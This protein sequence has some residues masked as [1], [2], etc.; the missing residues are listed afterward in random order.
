FKAPNPNRRY[1]I[2]RVEHIAAEC[3]DEYMKVVVRFNG[4]FTGL[5]YSSGYVHDPNCIY[6]NGSG[7]SYYEF[8]I[9]LNQCGTLG[10]QEMYHPT[11]PGEA[12]LMWNT[13]SI[14]Y[15]AM[16]EEE[17]DEHFRL[18]CE[19]GSDF[20]KTV[21]FPSVNVEINTG[22]PV[23]FTVNPPQ[24]QMEI[25]RGFGIAGSRTSGSVTVG[26]PLT[27]LIH[28]KSEKAGFDILVKNCVAHNGAQQRMQLIDSNG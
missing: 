28:M 16:I 13:L 14:Q 5:V 15:N 4:T 2:T 21:T 26:D 23:V 18:T 20:W 7:R 19:Y 11:M 3:S 27:L 9:R 8:F 17:F 12:R 6:V 25:R 10:R 22:S 24:C 1:N